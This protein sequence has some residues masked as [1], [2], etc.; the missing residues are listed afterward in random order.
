MNKV[1]R[2]TVVA[3]KSPL[4]NLTEQKPTFFNP[5]CF[6]DDLGVWLIDKLRAAG[7]RTDDQP[8][9]EDFGWYVNFT[10]ESQDFCAVIGHVPDTCWFVVVEARAGFISS[11]TGGRN[12]KVPLSGVLAVRDAIG[13][14]P[15]VS[16][17]RWYSWSDFRSR[18]WLNTPGAVDPDAA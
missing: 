17:V 3:F 6:G 15:D 4:F 5:D 13:L 16:E 9:A 1:A 12:H 10:V 14:I 8:G 2:R 7:H 18:E 11:V